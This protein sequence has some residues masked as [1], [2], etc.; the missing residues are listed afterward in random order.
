MKLIQAIVSNRDGNQI[1]EQLGRND[2]IVTKLSTTG[3]FL[4]KGNTTLLLVTDEELV[5]KAIEIIK[6]NST[7]REPAGA[8]EMAQQVESQGGRTIMVGGAVIFVLDVEKFEK[9]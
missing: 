6:N 3:G 8:S 4:R 5:E 2:F 1:M 7:K 9:I